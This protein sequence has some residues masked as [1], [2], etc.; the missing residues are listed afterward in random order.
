MRQTHTALIVPTL[1]A[2]VAW[3]KWLS[4]FEQQ[5]LKPDELMIIDSSSEDDTVNIAREHGFRVEIIDKKEFKHGATRRLGIEWVPEVEIIIF[6]TQ[7]A[8]L[9]DPKALE[10]LVREFDDPDVGASYGRQIPH[11]DATP[12][13]AHARLYNYPSRSRIN[14]RCRRPHPGAY[15]ELLPF[16]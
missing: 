6:L 5:T 3:E 9:A 1:N 7:D 14:R 15:G 10:Y 11:K 8:I 12:I 13:A 16:P 4:A 2:G